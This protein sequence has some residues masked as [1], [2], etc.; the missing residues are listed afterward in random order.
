MNEKSHSARYLVV[1]APNFP[2]S[3][4]S[5]LIEPTDALTVATWIQHNKND[6]DFIDL[7]RFGLKALDCLSFSDY[8]TVLIVFDYLIPLYTS[9]AINHF[10]KLFR[11]LS[12][13]S[14]CVLL[15]GR[16]ASCFPVEV[17]NRFSELYGCVI[18]EP[19]IVLTELFKSNNLEILNNNP[20]VLT[21]KNKTNKVHRSK[22]VKCKNIYDLF[23]EEGPIAN[24]NLCKFNQYIDVHSVISSRGCNGFCKF[25]STSG[26]VGAWRAASPQLVLSEIKHL[27]GLGAYKI[28]FL[29]DNFSNNKPRVKEICTLIKK[30]KIDIVWGCLCR[31]IDVDEDILKA[32]YDAGCRWI[33][34]GMEHGDYKVRSGVGKNF[35]DEKAIKAIQFA[36]KFGMRT[37][38]SWILDLP[39]ATEST[40]KKTFELTKEISSHEIKFHFLALRPGSKYYNQFNCSKLFSNNKNIHETYIHKGKPHNTIGLDFKKSIIDQLESFKEQMSKLDYQWVS[41]V[42][43]WKRFD[44]KEALP[45]EKFLSTSIIR[46]GLGWKK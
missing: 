38:T 28:I 2:Q 46:Y 22:E 37:R 21:Q 8:K 24:R 17:L 31:I 36:K 25:C 9:E 35:S 19:E 41:D 15:T 12:K 29:D 23:P 44:S 34:F 45:N 39:E 32:M 13:K 10:D 11:L 42:T 33:H 43:F 26:Y 18:G 3:N 5:I 6:V 40:V 20:Y 30:N 7:D 16:A 27:V 4:S 14:D 1:N